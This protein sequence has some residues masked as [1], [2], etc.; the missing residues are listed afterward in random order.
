MAT[1]SAWADRLTSVRLAAH[2]HAHTT[3]RIAALVCAG[4][5]V[6]LFLVPTTSRTAN[7]LVAVADLD[8]GTL[9]TEADV[10]VD[11]TNLSVLPVGTLNDVNQ[12]VGKRVVT[13]IRQGEVFTESRL[14][15]PHIIDDITQTKGGRAVPVRL[16]DPSV[17]QLLRAGDLVDVV[18]VPHS[19]GPGTIVAHAATVLFVTDGDHRSD[20]LAVLA[21]T[22]ET[23]IDVATH[24]THNRLTVTLH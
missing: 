16:A 9:I 19:D 12:A 21:L 18:A 14:L 11:P 4:V 10:R 13:P 22:P 2:E 15:T 23:A 6:A 24:A 3:R 7:M 5:A 20:S 17:T 1:S 8:A